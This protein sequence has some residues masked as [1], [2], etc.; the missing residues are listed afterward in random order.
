MGKDKLQVLSRRQDK[1]EKGSSKLRV[2]PE[3]QKKVENGSKQVKSERE[4]A[5]ISIIGPNEAAFEAPRET[6]SPPTKEAASPERMTARNR[7]S[8]VSEPGPQQPSK[9]QAPSIETGMEKTPPTKTEP[10][11]REFSP[12]PVAMSKGVAYLRGNMIRLT[13]GV[14]LHPGDQVKIGNRELILRAGKRK[15]T[16]IYPAAAAVLLTIL[17]LISPLF[18]SS[19]DA[20]LIGMVTQAGTGEII[21]DVTVHLKE[22]NR[23]VQ[24]NDLGFFVFEALPAGSYAITVASVGY[25]PQTERV[26]IAED[27]PLTLRVNLTPLVPDELA[28]GSTGESSVAKKSRGKKKSSSQGTTGSTSGTI[29]IESNVSDPTILIDNRLA[30]IGNDAFGDIEPGKHTVAVTREGYYDWAK[31]VN[32]KSGKTLTL[33]VKLSQDK[34]GHPD[35]QTWKDFVALGN[36][37][38]NANDLASALSSYNQALD[39][40]PDAPDALLGRG[41][42][43]QK[44]GDA[45]KARSDFEK[46]ASLFQNGHHYGNAALAYSNL[47]NLDDRNP[48]LYLNRGICYLRMGDNQSSV[49]DLKRAVDLDPDLFSGHLNLGEA[50]LRVG[51][52]KRSI[53]SYK[54]AK[55]IDSGNYQVFVGLAKAYYKKGDK[56]KAKKSYKEFEKLSTYIYREKLKEDPEW[57][58]MLG[59]IGVGS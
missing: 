41:Y 36:T 13:G 53:D 15:R 52:Y 39:L 1:T 29:R 10:N 33:E 45:L 4:D 48:H 19:H 50:Y 20:A 2:P 32:V 3:N 58:E 51:D 34:T 30:G 38:L 16:W 44:T 35:A 28:S 42:T 9:P 24:P 54:R 23:T 55:K 56:S 7:E 27:Q 8:G 59:D 6:K 17:V 57:K 31:E 21:P 46:S 40:K 22:L 47:I 14:R 37:Q 43:Y 5:S 49:S 11:P 25:Q 18:R 26:K 12:K